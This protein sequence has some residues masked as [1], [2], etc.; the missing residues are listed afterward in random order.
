MSGHS[1]TIK[2]QEN[3]DT[4]QVTLESSESLFQKSFSVPNSRIVSLFNKDWCTGYFSVSQDGPIYVESRNGLTMVVAQRS[5]RQN[6]TIHWGRGSDSRSITV[7]TPWCIGIF[8]LA[9]NSNDSTYLRDSYMYTTT[10]PSLGSYTQLKSAYWMGNV[11]QDN[12]VCWGTT[13][14]GGHDSLASV[15][16]VTN[17]MSDF[18]SEN[19]NSDLHSGT[20]QWTDYTETGNVPGTSIG[21]LSAV[22][23][24]IWRG[25]T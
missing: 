14:V 19:F 22:I 2:F 6:Q 10:G 18:F 23:H 16:S 1:V 24:R 25:L 13:S 7:N 12:R 11:Y 17:F 15:A 5:P 8:I 9:V 21:S 3:L 20:Q 4:A